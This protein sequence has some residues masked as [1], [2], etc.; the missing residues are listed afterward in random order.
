MIVRSTLHLL[1]PEWQGFGLNADVHRGARALAARLFDNR[2]VVTIDAPEEER[3]SVTD[4]VLG[5]ESIARRFE[6]ALATVR[7]ASPDRIL[8]VGGTCGVELAPIAYLN[9]RY[10]GDLAVLWLD[11]HAD[12]NTPATSPSGHFHGMPLRTL[13]GDGPA[14]CTRLIARP[15]TPRQVFLVGVREFDPAEAEYVARHAIPVLGDDE[16]REPERVVEAVRAAGYRRAYVHFDVDVLD[17][18]GFP[19]ALM[20]SAGGGPSVNDAMQVLAALARDLDIAGAS[21]LEYCER[22]PA[23]T[24]RLAKAVLGSGLV[25]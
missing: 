6:S 8:M 22:D 13:L 24:E 12:L 16:F 21:V 14:V 2:D 15:L 25:S 18:S 23:W 7:R 1:H 9:E 3:L 5:L 4:G 20:H 10:G 11:A 19:C 17:P